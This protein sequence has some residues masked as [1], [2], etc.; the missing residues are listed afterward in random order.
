MATI[1][2]PTIGEKIRNAQGLAGEKFLRTNL[3][4]R[5]HFAEGA[6]VMLEDE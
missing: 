6:F 5:D 2:Y 4:I 3:I 1:V